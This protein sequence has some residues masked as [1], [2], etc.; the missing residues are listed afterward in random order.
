LGLLNS[1]AGFGGL[2]AGVLTPW[3]IRKFA[4]TKVGVVAIGLQYFGI[5]VLSIGSLF[6]VFG[7]GFVL[8]EI[9]LAISLVYL[10]VERARIIP[11]KRIS[12]NSG[13]GIY[14]A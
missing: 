14:A 8:T 13:C 2:A 6:Y 4:P 1:V 3:A 11:V 9:A 12:S 10:S 5:I 7:L